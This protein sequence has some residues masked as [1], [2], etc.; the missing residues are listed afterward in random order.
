M[1]E[2]ET[3]YVAIRK[4]RDTKGDD[5]CWMDYENLFKLLPEGYQS[6]ERDTERSCRDPKCTYVSPQREIE[7][8][9]GIIA[10]NA[11]TRL[12]DKQI[13]TTAEDIKESINILVEERAAGRV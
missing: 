11:A 5:R 6:P 13:F 10:R 3:V 4:I 9:R 7:R 12:Q 1:T 8:L 2:L